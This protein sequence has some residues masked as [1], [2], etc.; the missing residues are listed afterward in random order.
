M[1]NILR[2]KPNP[3]PDCV[4]VAINKLVLKNGVTHNV[5]QIIAKVEFCREWV[6]PTLGEPELG[7]SADRDE[8]YRSNFLSKFDR[9]DHLVARDM[10]HNEKA[11]SLKKN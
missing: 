5:N 8:F 9:I 4:V 3:A 10:G 6:D 11:S 2:A 7:K 1:Q